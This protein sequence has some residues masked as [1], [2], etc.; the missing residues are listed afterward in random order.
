MRGRCEEGFQFE[1]ESQIKAEGAFREKEAN[2][3]RTR[4]PL[5]IKLETPV[6]NK[7]VP[8]ANIL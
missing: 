7:N 3:G 6:S 4:S 1:K 8:S 5:P 2:N